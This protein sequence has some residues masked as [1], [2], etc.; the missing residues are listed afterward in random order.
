MWENFL[1][2]LAWKMLNKTMVCPEMWIPNFWDWNRQEQLLSVIRRLREWYGSYWERMVKRCVSRMKHKPRVIIRIWMYTVAEEIWVNSVPNSVTVILS[3]R[4]CN[5]RD[6][7][8]RT[9]WVYSLKVCGWIAKGLSPL[10]SFAAQVRWKNHADDGWPR[11]KGVE[12]E[13]N[14]NPQLGN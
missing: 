2:G 1:V 9:W 12:P 6:L 8:L 10:D 5:L 3:G 7:S 13:G 11:K 14:L 4:C